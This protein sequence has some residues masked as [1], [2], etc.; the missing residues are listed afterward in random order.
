MNVEF[1]HSDGR[2]VVMGRQY[3][4]VLKRIGKGTY[5]GPT[6]VPEPKTVKPRKP[7]KTEDE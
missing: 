1:T 4:E 7:A 2:K 3:A 5:G 6:A